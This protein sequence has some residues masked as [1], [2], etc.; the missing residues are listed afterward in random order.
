VRG[1]S[2]G[3]WRIGRVGCC[4]ELRGACSVLRVV[5]RVVRRAW[6]VGRWVVLGVACC[7][8]RVLR[9]RV[10]MYACVRGVFH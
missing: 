5:R 10:H 9:V 6:G 1:A 4:A 3:A 7:L 2:R 8:L